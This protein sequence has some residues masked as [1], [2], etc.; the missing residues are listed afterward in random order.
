MVHGG[1]SAHQAA[2]KKP[3]ASYKSQSAKRIWRV[4]L[5]CIT[6]GWESRIAL[7]ESVRIPTLQAVKYLSPGL[8]G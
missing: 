7:D 1:N 5:L 4:Y 6:A 8:I 3:A 2:R